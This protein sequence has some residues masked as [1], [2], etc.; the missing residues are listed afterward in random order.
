[1]KHSFY[2]HRGG[3]YFIVDDALETRMVSMAMKRLNF[4]GLRRS[5]ACGKNFALVFPLF[6]MT[7]VSCIDGEA[8]SDPVVAR[9]IGALIE[10]GS[11]EA[12]I[13]LAEAAMRG[14]D[15]DDPVTAARYAPRDSVQRALFY[16]LTGRWEEYESLDFDHAYLRTAYETGDERLRGRIAQRARCDGRVEWIEIVTGGHWQRRWIG[17]EKS[18][19][20][21]TANPMAMAV[22]NVRGL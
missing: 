2:F 16:F 18:S 22:S 14:L 5:R 6:A 7:F 3:V 10:D 20:S 15:E 17:V 11:T 4:L 13:A 9:H 21:S 19:C 1:L 8:P 12:I